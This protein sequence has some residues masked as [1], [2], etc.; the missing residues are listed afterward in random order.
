MSC[1][2][3]IKLLANAI[4]QDF[5]DSSNDIQ[6][7]KYTYNLLG[8]NTTKRSICSLLQDEYIENR[9]NAKDE[10]IYPY[11]L[12]NSPDKESNVLIHSYTEKEFYFDFHMKKETFCNLL[13]EMKKDRYFQRIYESEIFPCTL[14][15]SLLMTIWYLAKGGTLYDICDKFNIN[16]TVLKVVETTINIIVR[17]QTKYVVW[18]D[19]NEAEIS[20]NIFLS[21]YG[22]P[23]IL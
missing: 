18:P 9:T 7:C 1:K 22:Y 20:S 11:T 17:L 19:E 2:K 23:G 15:K 12:Y 16:S 21:N 6:I 3:K 8:N 4:L 10:I 5:A 13:C 14:E